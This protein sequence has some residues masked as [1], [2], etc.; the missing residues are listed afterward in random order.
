MAPFRQPLASALSAVTA[1]A[2]TTSNAGTIFMTVLS[3]DIS[4][5]RPA[6]PRADWIT[7]QPVTMFHPMASSRGALRHAVQKCRRFAVEK[8][9][10]GG[11][12]AARGSMA[13]DGAGADRHHLDACDV[14][15]R[16]GRLEFRIEQVLGTGHDQRL[17]SDR[18]QRLGGVA[19]EA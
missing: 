16:R 4:T 3:C 18:G 2:A 5:S 10:V 17:R 7:P 11:N 13:G 19:V 1:N 8:F 12:G 9:D 6:N 15:G 14:F